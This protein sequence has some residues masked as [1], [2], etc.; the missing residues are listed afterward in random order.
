[1]YTVKYKTLAFVL[2]VV[3]VFTLFPERRLLADTYSGKCGENISWSFDGT[4]LLTIS[5]SG[6]MYD[7]NTDGNAPWHDYSYGIKSVVISD[8]VTTIGNC[9]FYFCLELESVVIPNTV[10][11]IGDGAFLDCQKLN[12]ITIPNSVKK[13]GKSAFG[14]CTSLT[15]ISIPYGITTLSNSVFSSCESLKSIS[16]PSSV[17]TIGFA[18]FSSCLS[19]KS[20][21]IPKSVTS[22]IRWSKCKNNRSC[23]FCL[24][25]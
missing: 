1:M 2:S 14:L 17:K 3:L 10:T 13:I 18:A 19:L 7:W 11:S 25:L 21:Y 15:S 24:L 6:P 20:I 23:S 8:N 5:G 9:A 16:I 12:N 4:G 22:I